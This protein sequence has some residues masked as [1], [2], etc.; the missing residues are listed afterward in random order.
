MTPCALDMRLWN[1]V[2]YNSREFLQRSSQVGPR[3]APSP[4]INL[5]GIST[6]MQVTAEQTN[7]C[8]LVL[9]IVVDEPQVSRAFES[10][11]REFSRYAKV[12]GFRPGKAPRAIVERYVDAAKVR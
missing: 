2:C 3:R 4:Q 11:Y 12:P 1:G 7:P 9:D 6:A 8:T 10:V 5:E